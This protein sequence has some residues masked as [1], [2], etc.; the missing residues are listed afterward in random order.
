MLFDSITLSLLVIALAT[1]ISVKLLWELVFSPLRAFPGPFLARFTDGWRS[2]L[3][4]LGDVDRKHLAWHRKWG[5]AV[6]VGPNAIS[7]NDPDLIKTLYGTKNPWRKV[8]AP[9]L[10][11]G[12]QRQP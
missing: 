3:T 5:S 2:Y 8:S 6:R 9:S 4:T 1:L 12:L 7:L 11:E 10:G